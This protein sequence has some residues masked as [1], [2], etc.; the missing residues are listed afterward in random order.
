MPTRSLAAKL[1][2]AGDAGELLRSQGRLYE[3]NFPVVPNEQTHWLDEQRATMRACALADLSHH[4]TSIHLEGPDAKRMLADLC[5]N[6]FEE[7][8]VGQAKQAVVCSPAGK[9]WGDGPVLRLDEE[10]FWGVPVYTG[11]WFTYNHETGD[12]DVDLTVEFPSSYFEGDPDSFIYQIQGPNAL[13]LLGELTDADLRDVGFYRFEQIDLAGHD[14][15][16]LGHGMSTEAGFEFHGPYSEAESV[17][18]AICE[19]GEEYGLR[20]L[21]SKAYLSQSVRLGW[22]PP[23]PPPI[24]HGG[25]LAEYLEW[26]PADSRA[27]NYSISGSYDPEDVR[28]YYMSP[29][30]LGYGNLIDFEHDFVGKEALAAEYEAPA[31][32]K[33]TLRWNDEDVID[34]FASLFRAGVMDGENAK[35]FDNLPRVGW[36]WGVFDEVRAGDELVGLSHSRSYE[37]DVPGMI[38]LAVVDTAYA[39]PGTEV[40]LVWGEPG[41]ASPNP[42]VEAHTQREIR[43]TVGPV[44]YAADRRKTLED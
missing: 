34:V 15:R 20:Q 42:K 37:P 44:P 11:D 10:E 24:Y 26:L 27:G 2:D 43:A 38:S 12:Y 16:V 40:T 14:V 21:G 18:Q 23:A 31:R 30:E 33:V 22:L 4:M 32:T 39:K 13:D 1:A 6:D 8:E 35:W 29:I 19:A 9:I 41:G 3:E 5:V 28:D 7:F 17:R 36:A 25:E